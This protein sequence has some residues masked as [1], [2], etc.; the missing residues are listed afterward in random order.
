MHQH[1]EFGQGGGTGLIAPFGHHGGAIPTTNGPQ[2]GKVVQLSEALFEFGVAH[3][4]KFL[5]L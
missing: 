4:E 1:R 5:I 2:V 3:D